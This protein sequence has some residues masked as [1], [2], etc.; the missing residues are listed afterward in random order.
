M[1]ISEA[2]KDATEAFEDVGHSDDARALL[3]AMLVGAIEGGVSG[4][5]NC[6]WQ[7]PF[8]HNLYSS[9]PSQVSKAKSKAAPSVN[10]AAQQSSK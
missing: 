6:A 4:V 1:L 10:Q 9:P 2:G 8:S 5:S 3:P 7:L